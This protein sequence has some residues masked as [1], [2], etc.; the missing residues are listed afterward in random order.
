MLVFLKVELYGAIALAASFLSLP[1]PNQS[2]LPPSKSTLASIL[3]PTL[4][5]RALFTTGQL[6]WPLSAC[7]EEDI[8]LWYMA[9]GC[10]E[11]DETGK[12]NLLNRRRICNMEPQ[13]LS[14]ILKRQ[15]GKMVPKKSG[16]LTKVN[17]PRITF[18][19]EERNECIHLPPW[20]ARNIQVLL[21]PQRRIQRFKFT[22]RRKQAGWILHVFPGNALSLIKPHFV[23]TFDLSYQF[24]IKF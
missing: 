12:G 1:D 13:P 22:C 17:Q 8:Q 6:H 15:G 24:K 16:W 21:K 23:L 7:K 3:S 10:E 14:C 19:P 18:R 2:L 11:R 5:N 20:R 4:F 9:R